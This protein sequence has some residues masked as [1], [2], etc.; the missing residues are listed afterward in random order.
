MVA[1]PGCDAVHLGT[2]HQSMAF[3]WSWTSVAHVGMGS[4]MMMS[5]SLPKQ[6]VLFLVSAVKTLTVMACTDGVNL[7]ISPEAGAIS[8]K[9]VNITWLVDDV[10]S[11]S[12]VG[13]KWII[14][15]LYV[16]WFYYGYN[17]V[18][19]LITYPHSTPF[20]HHLHYNTTTYVPKI[21]ICIIPQSVLVSRCC[22]NW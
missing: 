1:S 10:I 8:V 13:V 21:L 16:C 20:L 5:L 22:T 18:T 3:S 9:Q 17:R 2:S 15:P 14:S 12:V 6:F 19:H 11:V 7:T 4:R